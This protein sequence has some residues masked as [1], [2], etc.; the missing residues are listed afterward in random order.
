MIIIIWQWLLFCATPC[1]TQQATIQFVFISSSW[2]YNFFVAHTREK[3]RLFAIMALSSSRA[4]LYI[5]VYAS[6]R[7][8]VLPVCFINGTWLVHCIEY[9]LQA[10]IST[11]I[12]VLVTP[13]WRATTLVKLF[14]LRLKRRCNR[15]QRKCNMVI[16]WGTYGPDVPYVS[17]LTGRYSQL[18]LTWYCPALGYFDYFSS[19]NSWICNSIYCLTSSFEYRIR[20]SWL[21]YKG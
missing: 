3:S 7:I 6:E 5:N 14:V 12:I 18:F 8:R 4:Y 1:S 2:K 9:N 21:L 19:I 15:M 17:V 16:R 20:T 11:I 10:L 13:A